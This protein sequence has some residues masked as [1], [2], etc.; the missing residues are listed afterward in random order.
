MYEYVGNTP[1]NLKRK[2]ASLA[3]VKFSSSKGF[4]QAHRG[5]C[6]LLF[7]QI[8]VYKKLRVRRT[9]LFAAGDRRVLRQL[10]LVATSLFT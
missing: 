10:S 5:C 8:S 6:I 9:A 4:C 7:L 3:R 2:S 1:Y